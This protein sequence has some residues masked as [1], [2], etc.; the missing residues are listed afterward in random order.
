LTQP[1]K[2][3]QASIHQRLLNVSKQSGRP[4]N[5]VA[6][7][8]AIER[9]LYRLARSRHAENI[10]LKGGLLLRVWEVSATRV[11]RD[12]DLLGKLSNDPGQIREIVRELCRVEVEDDG[13][14]F[15]PDTVTTARIAEDADY[16]GVRA[17]F[18]GRFG[19]MPLAMQID[20]G[21]SDVVTPRPEPITYPSVL[22]HP[23]A[24]LMAYNRETVVAEKFEAMVKLGELNSR[25]KDFFDVY[26]LAQHFAFEGLE[27]ADAIRATFERRG[28]APESRPVCF[29]DEF[30]ASESK[31]QQWAAFL[32]TSRVDQAPAQ[33]PE[34][35]AFITGFL[36][37]VAA[38]L[39]NRQAF[40]SRWPAGGPWIKES[41]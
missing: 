30:S 16:E 22:D 34:V 8:Y 41:M 37:P 23:P 31:T 35:I 7:Y 3:I 14:T 33:F 17:G 20:F 24:R 11:T 6:M 36:G 27:V 5:D 19:K 10:V 4:F 21:F 2:N 39:A 32:K 26:V 1:P 38:S 25:M 40:D 15:D 13:L 18:Q 9:F 29:G 28:T 12:I